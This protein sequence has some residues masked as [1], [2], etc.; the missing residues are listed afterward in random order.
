MQ[1]VCLI[2]TCWPDADCAGAAA[3]VAVDEGLCACANLLPGMTSIYRWED[4]IETASE[5]VALFKTTT[6][7]APA[8][9]VRLAE[10]HPYDEPAIL[11]LPVDAAGS[12]ASFLTWIAAQTGSGR[13]NPA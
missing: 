3:R 10:L 7:R 12:A 1:G 8:L 6:A 11:G 9:V 4:R 2:Y 13:G 5:C